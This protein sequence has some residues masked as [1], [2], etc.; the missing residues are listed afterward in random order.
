MIDPVFLLV[1]FTTVGV[2][3]ISGL[4]FTFSN[5]AMTAF[6]GLPSE[7]GISAMQAINVKIINPVFLLV[8]AGSGLGSI[9]LSVV[10]ITNWPVEGMKWILAGALLY[11][12]GCIL[13]TARFNVPLNDRLAAVHP[14]DPSS[15]TIWRDYIHNW[16]PWNHLRTMASSAAVA[17]FAVGL[18]EM[19]WG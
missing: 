17:A 2:A 4:L 12:I 9:A 11:L 5:F 6:G 14:T 13:V 18:A 1:L 16:L 8:F 19:G 15:E 10:A 7:Q 3:I